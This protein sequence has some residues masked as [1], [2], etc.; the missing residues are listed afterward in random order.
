VDGVFIGVSNF[1]ER[2]DKIPTPAN[3]V[4]AAFI[5]SLFLNAAQ[6]T[7]P[8]SQVGFNASHYV[9]AI[10]DKV[11]VI[12]DSRVEPAGR[13]D[14]WVDRDDYVVVIGGSRVELFADLRLDPIDPLWKAREVTSLLK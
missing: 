6:Q 1:G 2:A 11:P 14:G 8:D 9:A 10:S 3:A 5:Y 4:G 13:G 12:G 7:L